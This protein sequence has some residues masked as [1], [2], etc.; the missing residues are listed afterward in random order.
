MVTAFSLRVPIKSYHLFPTY[1]ADN[2]CLLSESS[3]LDRSILTPLLQVLPGQI[4]RIDT[5]CA[6]RHGKGST[7]CRVSSLRFS[8][9]KIL[10]AHA[11]YII[12]QVFFLSLIQDLGLDPIAL[13]VQLNE[14]D[15]EHW[16]HSV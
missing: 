2:N 16:R 11:Y 1:S 14:L 9:L 3:S 7:F 13:Q 10:N 4:Y 8:L 6:Y 15:N 5:Q 12:Y